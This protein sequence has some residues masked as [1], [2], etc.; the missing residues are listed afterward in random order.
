[1]SSSSVSAVRERPGSLRSLQNL[2]DEWTPVIAARNSASTLHPR[3]AGLHSPGRRARRPTARRLASSQR[4]LHGE[5]GDPDTSVAD[6]IGDIDPI[7]VAEG[8]TLGDPETIAFGLIPRAH[9]GIVAPST[10]CP[11]WPSGS[12][13]PC[14]T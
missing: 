12:R 4:A 10:S 9:R 11:T 8:R 13:S 5:A 2:L 14:S 3:H 7:K 6:L 1:M